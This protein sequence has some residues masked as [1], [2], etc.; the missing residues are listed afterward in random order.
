MNTWASF[1]E[2]Y[3]VAILFELVLQVGEI[4]LSKSL[5]KKGIDC[6]WGGW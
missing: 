2:C 1:R 3:I 4:L 6:R 5:S